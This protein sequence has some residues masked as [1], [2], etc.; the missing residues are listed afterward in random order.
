MTGFTQCIRVCLLGQE[1][2][3][4][5]QEYA[6]SLREYE[7]GCGSRGWTSVGGAIKDGLLSL[8]LMSLCM[9]VRTAFVL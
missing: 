5:E 2:D 6:E 9:M 7:A 8:F 4:R 1:R 3:R